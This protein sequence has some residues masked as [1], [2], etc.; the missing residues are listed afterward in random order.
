MLEAPLALPDPPVA[1]AWWPCGS[2]QA[3]RLAAAG[4]VSGVADLAR[5][6]VRVVNREPGSQARQVLDR[7]LLSLGLEPDALPGYDAS[8]C[9]ELITTL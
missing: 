6:G 9:G 7:E 3:L 4:L 2:E 5:P 1:F 8:R